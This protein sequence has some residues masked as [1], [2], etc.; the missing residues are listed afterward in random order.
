MASIS[1]HFSLTIAV[2]IR[3]HHIVQ[4]FIL[5]SLYLSIICIIIFSVCTIFDCVLHHF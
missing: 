4:P 5:A 1:T 2:D 3:L